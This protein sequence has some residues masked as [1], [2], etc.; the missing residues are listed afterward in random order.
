MKYFWIYTV[1]V[2]F[3]LSSCKKTPSKSS[4]ISKQLKV[5]QIDFEYFTS[6]SKLNFQTP[7][8]SAKVTLNIRMKKDSIIWM[9]VR[10]LSFEG[11]RVLITK[12]SVFI[13]NR[14]E[15]SYFA[16]DIA[17]LGKK[18]NFDVNL[19]MIQAMIL[20]NVLPIK[21]EY[22]API[23]KKERFMVVQDANE[24][25]INNYISRT[26]NKLTEI[27]AVKKGTEDKLHIT[28]DDFKVLGKYLFPYKAKS[29]IDFTFKEEKQHNDFEIE[30]NKVSFSSEKISFPFNRPSKYRQKPCEKTN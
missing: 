21:S 19:S 18:I 4:D 24:F 6:K 29:S 9:S 28:Y 10:K 2:L 26:N 20:G 17:A 16:C 5:E 13:I 11:V 7:Q 22:A 15:R 27:Q 23:K 8:Q 12:D 30:H 14:L 1:L 3:T 25:L